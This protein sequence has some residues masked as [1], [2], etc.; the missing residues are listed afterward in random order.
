MP[1]GLQISTVILIVGCFIAGMIIIIRKP[2]EYRGAK[3]LLYMAFY[4]W[5]LTIFMA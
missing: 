5:I 1:A 4:S 3:A 2:S